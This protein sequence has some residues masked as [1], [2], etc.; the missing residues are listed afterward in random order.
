MLYV[1]GIVDVHRFET[2]PSEGHEA[3]DV[4]PVS[5]GA[6]AAAVSV[7][8]CRIIAATPHGLRR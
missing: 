6:F 1:Y 8:S 7:L 3:S 4:V 2:I 5:C